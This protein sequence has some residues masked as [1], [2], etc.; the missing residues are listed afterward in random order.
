MATEF[1]D[2]LTRLVRELNALGG[3]ASL[4]AVERDHSGT[5]RLDRV[6]RRAAEAGA[7][8]LLLVPGAPA[9]GRVDGRLIALDPHPLDAKAVRGLCTEML[10]DRASRE[11]EARLAA[12]FCFE[13]SGLG[14]F[15]ANVHHQRGAVAASI[16]LLP[17][18]V[19]TIEELHLPAALER[20]ASLG[21]G[22]VLL[23]GPAG[24]GK[25]TTLAALVGILNRTRNAHVILIEDPSEYVFQ[26]GTS[27]VEQIEVGRD[28]PSFSEAIRSAVRQDPDVI[29]VGEMR[30]P[31][32]A[33]MAL[34]A[35]ETGHLV[36]STLHTATVPQ[37]L[38]RIVDMFPDDRQPQVRA[39]MSLTLAGIVIQH[40]I[41][42]REGRGRVPA[43][44][45][46]LANDGVRNLIRKGMNHQL[47]AQITIGRAAGMMSLDESLARLVRAGVIDREEGARRASHLD[48]FESYLR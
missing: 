20:F 38:D 31:E 18:S 32:T 11:L 47:P 12:D 4:P 7:S 1:D 6:L 36:F 22:L 23:A 45:L 28:T 40:L 26:A 21:R 27:L 8:D 10:T 48:E 13:R 19:P 2:E 5:L 24:C 15:R 39:Q 25:S 17:A 34:T 44:E 46:L 43:V 14:R 33:A 29:A 30:D 9:T 16:R 42:R 37:T 35:A 3:P 41:P